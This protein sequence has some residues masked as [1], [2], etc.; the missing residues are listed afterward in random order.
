MIFL[1]SAVSNGMLDEMSKLRRI[2]DKKVPNIFIDM[3]SGR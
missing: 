2:S 1:M 3:P